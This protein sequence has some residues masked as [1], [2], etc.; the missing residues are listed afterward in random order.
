MAVSTNNNNT[1][2]ENLEQKYKKKTTVWNWYKSETTVQ[3][4]NKNLDYMIYQAFSTI[5]KWFLLLFKTGN[6][7]AT[8]FL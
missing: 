4:K 7:N 5:S 3:P 6:D 2:L 1:F 8:F